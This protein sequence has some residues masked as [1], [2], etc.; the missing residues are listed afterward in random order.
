MLFERFIC[1]H[2]DLHTALCLLCLPSFLN[3]W[4]D[5]RT[6]NFAGVYILCSVC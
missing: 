1:M 2:V 4:V 5:A 3:E 6:D